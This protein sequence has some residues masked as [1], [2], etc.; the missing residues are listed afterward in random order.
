M[1][2]LAATLPSFGTQTPLPTAD[3]LN[4][5]GISFRAALTYRFLFAHPSERHR[6]SIRLRAPDHRLLTM[7]TT[8]ANHR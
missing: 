2:G 8:R 6:Q 3:T 1:A 5:V 4:A 7:N